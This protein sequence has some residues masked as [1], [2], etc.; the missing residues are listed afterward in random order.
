MIRSSINFKAPTKISPPSPP[1]LDELGVFITGAVKMSSSQRWS[2][3]RAA[4]VVKRKAKFIGTK[5]TSLVLLL[6]TFSYHNRLQNVTIRP[7]KAIARQSNNP[8]QLKAALK[9]FK[10]KKQQELEFVRPA[11]R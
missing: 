4:F 1:R 7:I 9:H 6:A 10:L 3:K 5:L 8:A 11:V 2:I